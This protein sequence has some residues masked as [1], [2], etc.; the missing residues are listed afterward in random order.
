M[1]YT[2][3]TMLNNLN[4]AEN[5][6]QLK[7]FYGINGNIHWYKPPGVGMGGIF[8]CIPCD[9][10]F[11][12]PGMYS[13]ELHCMYIKRYLQACPQQPYSLQY[14]IGKKPQCPHTL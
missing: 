5:L 12:F 13:K 3:T 14:Q 7:P 11:S 9:P 10:A 8:S 2:P 1:K 4:L 6:E